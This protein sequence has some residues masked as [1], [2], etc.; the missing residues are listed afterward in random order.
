MPQPPDDHIRLALAHVSAAVEGVERTIHEAY[1]DAAYDARITAYGNICA[2]R[3]LLQR[4]RADL[5]LL[6]RSVSAPGVLASES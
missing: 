2:K 6:H 4:V 5:N 1:A 3:A